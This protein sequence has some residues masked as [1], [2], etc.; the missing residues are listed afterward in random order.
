MQVSIITTCTQEYSTKL[1]AQLADLT[2]L[3]RSPLEENARRKA[4]HP[5]A[6]QHVLSHTKHWEQSMRFMQVHAT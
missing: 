3:V 4:R 2:A 5:P 1:N 6:S